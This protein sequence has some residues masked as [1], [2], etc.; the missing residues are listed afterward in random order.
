MKHTTAEIDRGLLLR[1][2][3]KTV[4]DLH[5][6]A[7]RAAELGDGSLAAGLRVLADEVDSLAGRAAVVMG[8]RE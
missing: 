6:E 8:V 4:A 7:L 3:R 2:V 5:A 1:R